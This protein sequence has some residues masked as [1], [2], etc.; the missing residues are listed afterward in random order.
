M[1][2]NPIAFCDPRTIS[3]DDIVEV[4][5]VSNISLTEVFYLKH[6]DT[7][8]WFWLSQQALD[9]PAM[10][11]QFDSHPP[12]GGIRGEKLLSFANRLQIANELSRSTFL[13]HEPRSE[14]RMHSSR[15]C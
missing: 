13:V 2:D 1:E 7:Y 5:R 3:G 8:R 12:P 15:E 10:F 6:K 11:V 14:R 4:D 9:E